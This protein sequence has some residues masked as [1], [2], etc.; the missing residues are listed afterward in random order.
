VYVFS[1]NCYADKDRI[2]AAG[3][4]LNGDAVNGEM[5]SGEQTPSGDTDS[6]SLDASVDGD[7]AAS[8]V[9]KQDV[10]M[11]TGRRENC[12]AAREAM[13]VCTWCTID[14]ELVL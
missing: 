4:V 7:T 13:L 12:E 5:T 10:I 1:V 8:R 11:I 3:S 9:Y 6:L 2:L 14:D